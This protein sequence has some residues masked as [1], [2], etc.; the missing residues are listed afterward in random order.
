MTA[1]PAVLP[2]NRD[3]EVVSL[4]GC[5]HGVSHFFHLLLPSLFPWL[6]KDF[7]LSFTGIGATMTVFFV[8]SAIGQA[9]AG[10][11]VDRYGAARVLGSGIG[12]FLVAS[13]LLSVADGYA[14]LVVVAALAGLG[15]SVFHPADFTVLNRHVSPPRLSYAFSIHGLSGNLGW[16]LAPVF[17]TGIA[18][19]A[20]W[21]PSHWFSCSG[22][23][24]RWPIRRTAC[25]PLMSRRRRR[26]WRSC[27]RRR[28]GCVLP[29][30][31]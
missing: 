25:R 8:V 13:L 18:A 14:G 28:Y 2:P 27:V 22:V 29:F 19:T 11:L 16:A 6:M 3:L 15:N 9:L 23:G 10:F 21:R 17:M 30:S 4:I 24:A 5:A 12:C 1:S 7:A 26:F 31:F 20:G